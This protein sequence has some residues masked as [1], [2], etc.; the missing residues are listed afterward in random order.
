MSRPGGWQHHRRLGHERSQ[1]LVAGVVTGDGGLRRPRAGRAETARPGGYPA[2]AV[3]AHQVP[4]STAAKL[5]R[6][7]LDRR[8]PRIPALPS[9]P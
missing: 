6:P 4:D 8:P 5:P 3:V 2:Q 1:V 9:D 7:L